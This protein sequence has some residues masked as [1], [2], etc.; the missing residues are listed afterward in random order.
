[1]LLSKGGVVLAADDIFVFGQDPE[2]IVIPGFDSKES[3]VPIPRVPAAAATVHRG[4]F[5]PI[6]VV[7]QTRSFEFAASACQL[8]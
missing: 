4:T 1:M 6:G 5:E 3:P 8:I 2:E 7:G